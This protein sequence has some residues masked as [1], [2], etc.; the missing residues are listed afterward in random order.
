M[1][2]KNTFNSNIYYGKLITHHYIVQIILLLQLTVTLSYIHL[3]SLCG[4]T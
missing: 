3:Q 1:K 2:T 4:L